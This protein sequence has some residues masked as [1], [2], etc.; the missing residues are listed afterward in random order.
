MVVEANR[1]YLQ[2]PMG[3]WQHMSNWQNVTFVEMYTFLAIT[4]LTGLIHKNRI[5]DYWNTNPLLSTLIFGQYFTRNRYQNILHYIHIGNNEDISSNDRLEKIR[6]AI[7]NFTG[8]FANCMNST[9]YLC[10]D[11]N[12]L[13]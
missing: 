11:E 2:D 12:L 10:I 1:Y 3:E 4:M 7:D 5:R 8:K 9:Q 6:P 13:L